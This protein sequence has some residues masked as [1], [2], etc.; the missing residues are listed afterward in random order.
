MIVLSREWLSSVSLRETPSR[1]HRVLFGESPHRPLATT[2]A[3]CCAVVVLGIVALAIDAMTPVVCVGIF[4]VAIVLVGFWLPWRTAPFALAVA[5]TFLSIAGYWLSGPSPAVAVWEL[6][7]SRASDI[8]TI[9][10][11]TVFVW[12][13]RVLACRFAPKSTSAMHSRAR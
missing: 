1:P 2:I 5:V 6:D 10:L 7:V 3:A 11:T 9:W 4:Y 13:I 12:Y 8:A